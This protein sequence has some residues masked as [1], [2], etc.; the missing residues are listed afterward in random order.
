MDLIDHPDGGYAYVPGIS[1]YSA[2]VRA[3]AG[4]AICRVALREPLPWRAG[5]EEIDRTVA[6]ADRPVR[7]LCSIELRTAAPHS[8]GAFGT[9]N[10]EYRAALDDRGVLLA[11][12]NP[13][14]R[15]NV[16]PSLERLGGTV[17][18]AFG[19]TIPAEGGRGPSFIVSGAGDLRDQADLRPEAIVGGSSPWKESGPDRASAVLDE[20]ESRLDGLGVGWSDT[21]VVV[22][23]T[24]QPLH[25]VMQSVILRRIGP[26]ASRRGLLWHL[27]RPPIAGLLFEMD[28]RGGVVERS[29]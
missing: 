5:F 1:P 8:F 29:G 16:A 18:H 14:A 11:G 28:A 13:V 2:G 24:E 3:E 12:V 27:A 26:Q 22:A 25:P 17:L 19:F 10:D 4:Y 15:T 20:L 23:Y 7:A 21:D 6:E 9:F